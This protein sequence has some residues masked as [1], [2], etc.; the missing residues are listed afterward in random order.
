LYAKERLYSVDNEG[1]G[2]GGG[3]FDVLAIETR[4]IG[5]FSVRKSNMGM[6]NK[7]GVSL[8]RELKDKKINAE[9][10]GG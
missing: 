7:F 10:M 6:G 8:C 3:T 1:A 5:K 4:R 9:K 2:P